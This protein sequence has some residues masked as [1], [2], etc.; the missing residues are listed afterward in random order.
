ME[1]YNKD[2]GKVC[3]T[4]EGN[5][6]E[7]KPYE[8]LS[9]VY[10]PIRR[11]SYLS[12]TD[13][14]KGIHIDNTEYWQCIGSG[15]VNDDCV[16]N[17]SYIDENNELVTYTLQEAITT[18]N[19]DDR[20]VGTLLTFFEK[21]EDITRQPGW[22]LYQFNS[23]SID[24]W[25]NLNNWFPVYHNR[26]K[27]VGWYDNES[28]LKT[29]IPLP[30]PGDYS[31]VGTD[32]DNSNI[33][34]CKERGVWVNTNVNVRDYMEIVISG[35]I[36]I[37]NEG[38]WA[39]D[40]VDTGIKASGIV[41]A[42]GIV[43]E[44]P[45]GDSPTIKLSLEDV[46]N[47]I[48]KKLVLKLGIPGGKPGENADIAS[49]TADITM[50]PVG[51]APSCGVTVSGPRDAKVLHFDFKIPYGGEAPTGQ[52]AFTIY[53]ATSNAR[54]F[55]NGA[56][57]HSIYLI[58]GSSVTWSVSAD[59]YITK[60]GS[61]VVDEDTDIDVNLDKETPSEPIYSNLRIIKDDSYVPS[62]DSN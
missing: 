60:S 21:T 10:D 38:N 32:Y 51:Q 58:E 59:G 24:N 45:Y 13:V 15:K 22:A 41:D 48:G 6:I 57:T 43:E 19:V 18:V 37:N 50:L 7:N 25:N 11:K 4:A 8:K 12:K 2:L 17:L 62:V 1:I 44:H 16:I 53:S 47:E 26:V 28:E 36:S 33:Y 61:Q 31:Y 14:P 55:I 30:Y 40:G 42:Q 49:A 39:I 56:E 52:V 9:I 46:K 35:D 23:I 29:S 20:R 3:V 5:H 34:K 27:F 54:I